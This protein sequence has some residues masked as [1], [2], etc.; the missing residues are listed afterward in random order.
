MDF[1]TGRIRFPFRRFIRSFLFA[2]DAF[3]RKRL[4]YER[5]RIRM[6]IAFGVGLAGLVVW[7]GF[8]WQDS[9]RNHIGVSTEI[10]WKGDD[11][12]AI[13]RDLDTS[14]HADRQSTFVL[15]GERD[16]D[17]QD[18]SGEVQKNV[19][20]PLLVIDPQDRIVQAESTSSKY[21]GPNLLVMHSSKE[22]GKKGAYWPISYYSEFLKYTPAQC[23]N[24][25]NICDREWDAD[26]GDWTYC[27]D[28]KN[29]ASRDVDSI[30]HISKLTQRELMPPPRVP[31]T[32]VAGPALV[33]PQ[34]P[35]AAAPE[36][37]AEDEDDDVNSDSDDS[38]SDSDDSLGGVSLMSGVS[39]QSGPVGSLASST[40]APSRP[41]AA[42]T[43]ATAQAPA[44]APAATGDA[45]KASALKT[46][47]VDI[48]R[49]KRITKRTK[50]KQKKS[51]E[52]NEAGREGREKA[53][54]G[55]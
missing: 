48:K 41:I 25:E 37:P 33:T 12:D 15:P 42:P 13:N 22:A 53:D 9:H 4:K 44:Q 1:R 19:P 17:S 20:M 47:E 49:L 31:R 27:K 36:N 28:I 7:A 46:A 45:A 52:G 32:N 3:G 38:D 18:D 6:G 10:T 54:V 35:Q 29:R 43:Q 24:I 5:R 23:A 50:K 11:F 14:L 51:R 34:Q 8:A 2:E 16:R 40:S 21:N 26:I 39:H 30:E 55:R